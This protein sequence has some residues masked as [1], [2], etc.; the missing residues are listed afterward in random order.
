MAEHKDEEHT[1]RV[2]RWGPCGSPGAMMHENRD[3]VL[4]PKFC[5]GSRLLL[6]HYALNY[7]FAVILS[8]LEIYFTPS[9]VWLTF[10]AKDSR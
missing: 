8:S 5:K 10:I 2:T 4:I 9:I 3:R 1:T 7:G 6:L